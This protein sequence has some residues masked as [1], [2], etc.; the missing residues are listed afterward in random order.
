LPEHLGGRSRTALRGAI[1]ARPSLLTPTADEVQALDELAVRRVLP[2]GDGPLL[3]EQIAPVEVRPHP[4]EEHLLG[5]RGGARGAGHGPRPAEE[6]RPLGGGQLVPAGGTV[7]AERHVAVLG[8]RG[9]LKLA[10]GAPRL[11][12]A[13]GLHGLVA[14]HPGLGRGGVPGGRRGRRGGE[15][16]ARLAALP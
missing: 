6:L 1:S 7:R 13:E 5:H 3:G 8:G 10:V 14:G 11:R 9:D 2:G 4:V 15:A 12:R 16:D